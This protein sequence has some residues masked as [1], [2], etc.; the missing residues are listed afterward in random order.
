MTRAIRCLVGLWLVLLL[1][2]PP[3]GPGETPDPAGDDDVGDDDDVATP[4]RI[5]IDGPARASFHEAGSTVTI[6]GRCIEGDAPLHAL[7]ID[8]VPISLADD[9]SF[10][11]DL[12]P[13]DGINIVD[14]ELE[15]QAEE[16]AV[17]AMALHHGPTHPPGELITSAMVVQVG[18]AL[19]DDDEPDLDDTA[20]LVEGLLEDP[21]TFT[22]LPSITYEYAELRPTSMTI[23][24]A[25]VDLVAHDGFLAVTTALHDLYVTF[26]AQGTGFWDWVEVS[27]E[28]WVDPA[29]V[30]MELTSSVVGGDVQVAVQSMDVSLSNLQMDVEWVPD[31]LEDY[32]AEYIQE[33]VEEEVQ[34]T[35]ETL[36]A[37]FLAELLAAAAMEFQFSE[38]IPVTLAIELHSIDVTSAGLVY[39]LD[40]R[41]FADPAFDLHPLAGSLR[42]GGDP[43]TTPF[44]TAPLA[45]ATDDDFANQ[46][47][48]AAWHAGGTEWTFSADELAAM[49]AEEI[50]APLGPVASADVS[51]QLPMVMTPTTS[52]S[53][54]YDVAIGEVWAEL[55][56]T[57]GEV[58]GFSVSISAGG[59]VE[60]SADGSLAMILDDRPAEVRLGVSTLQYPEGQV[61]ANL[62]ALVTM[63]VPPMLAQGNEGVDGFFL[64]QVGLEE[65]AD[66]DFLQGKSIGLTDPQVG[67][68]DGEGL[69]LLLEAGVLVQ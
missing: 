13:T 14:L 64:P 23:S 56:R 19:L 25:D 50:P 21:S 32:L 27:G 58:L 38:E 62:A 9:G 43:P 22:D 66:I 18:Q 47:M 15:D 55:E 39:T 36:I 1:G 60:P 52:D 40:A 8:D 6:H 11:H 49:G 68:V 29:T 53:F 63:I 65:M 44:S 41:A 3:E 10:S 37:D 20:S 48:F 46:L 45:V 51:I 31:D 30:S 33:Y 67:T 17:E 61:P 7:T 42:S 69:W 4:P 35:A 28:A 54:D 57:D 34:A 5:V 12:H 24:S 16:R 59:R 26:E 2:C